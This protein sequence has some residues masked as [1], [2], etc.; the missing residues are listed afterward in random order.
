MVQ[1]VVELVKTERDSKTPFVTPKQMRLPRPLH[2]TMG[3]K[4]KKFQHAFP[5]QCGGHHFNAYEAEDQTLILEYEYS[6]TGQSLTLIRDYVYGPGGTSN[7]LLKGG[8]WRQNDHAV[9]PVDDREKARAERQAKLRKNLQRANP[10]SAGSGR[11]ARYSRGLE[12][13]L[14]EKQKE[15]YAEEYQ[16]ALIDALECSGS[17]SEDMVAAW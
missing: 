5:A 11:K 6:P 3:T 7:A 17:L 2:V 15:F 10:S 12:T 8:V 13:N 16:K 1:H 14:T 4:I 9:L